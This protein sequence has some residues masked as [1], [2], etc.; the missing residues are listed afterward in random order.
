MLQRRLGLGELRLQDP[1]LLFG[2][3]FGR[4]SRA[5]AAPAVSRRASACWA[6]CTL[7]HLHTT[8]AS[9]G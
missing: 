6:I 5:N 3:T 1:D 4:R 8:G 7:G 9:I 2:R